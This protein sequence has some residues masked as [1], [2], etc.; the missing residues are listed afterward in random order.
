MIRPILMDGHP[1]LRMIADPVE[2]FDEILANLADDMIETMRAH[3]GVGLAAPQIGVSARVIVVETDGTLLKM[4]NPMITRSSGQYRSVEGC[5]SV[6]VS[7]WNQ[8]VI[9]SAAIQFEY[10]DL[11]GQPQR[12]KAKNLRAAVIQHEIEHLNGILF[13]DHIQGRKI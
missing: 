11:E 12:S 4:V 5:L 3:R 2:R 7:Q 8:P 6:P 13:T 10:Q 9:R 1:I